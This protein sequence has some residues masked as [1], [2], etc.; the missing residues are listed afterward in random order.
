[1]IKVK[2]P[3]SEWLEIDTQGRKQAR[4]TSRL[5]CSFGEELGNS[6]ALDL[7]SIGEAIFLADRAFRRG[8]RLGQ[9]VRELSVE[10]PVAQ[11]E[12]W[13]SVSEMIASLAEFATGDLW[14][15]KFTR[16]QYPMQTMQ[17]VGLNLTDPSICL[18][19]D[20]I[21]SLC[22]VAAALK[23]GETPVLVSHSPP[24]YKT[25]ASIAS[26]LSD[27]IGTSQV[28]IQ[29]V[30]LFFRASD[31][32]PMGKRNQ[33]VERSRRSRPVLYLTLA[34]AVA[35]ELDIPRIL[36]NENGPLAINFPFRPHLSSPRISRHAHPDTL[37]KF[38]ALLHEIW[39]HNSKPIVQNPFE[40]LTKGE[41]LEFLDDAKNL[42]RET[43]SCEYAR[44]QMAVVRAWCRNHGRRGGEA[45]ECGLCMPCLIRRAAMHKAQA[46]EAPY[47]Y[48]FDARSTL[49][50]REGNKDAPLY[51]RIAANVGDLYTYCT[52]IQKMS[53]NEFVVA[54]LAELGLLC[55]E[56]DETPYIARRLFK[57]YRRFADEFLDY[58]E[59]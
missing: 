58:I 2:S 14:S 38:E 42:A 8:S 26:A 19:S 7:L 50:G 48:A 49:E 23:R 43:T 18:F 45:K 29:Y 28:E 55:D 35:I 13:A 20:G 34:G 59:G 6:L 30:N 15:F 33:F 25:V 47:H 52:R 51:G 22:G 54:H 1:M 53:P 9:Q 11:V 40:T 17:K 10:V 27:C 37:R 39:P 31:R 5:R 21:D 24:G 32:D 44:Q 41:E 3:D 36:V 56:F 57:L 16:S 4:Y 46:K 12:K